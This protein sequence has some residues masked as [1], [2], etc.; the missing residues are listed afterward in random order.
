MSMIIGLTGP[1]GSGK[2]S[3]AEISKKFGLRVIDCD[4][5]ARRAVEP[6]T[7]GLIELEK[8]FG[9]EILNADG[10]LNRSRLAEIAFSAPSKTRLLNKTLLPFIARL[11]K[12]E[13][14]DEPVLLDAPTLFESGVD[15]ICDKTVAI[16]SDEDIRIKRIISR[17][18]LTL[19]Q[20][21][22]RVSAGKDDD[23]YKSRADY[24]LYNNAHPDDFEA[25]V[26]A[27]FNTIFGGKQND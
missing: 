21:K 16:L 11:V 8:V 20:A 10:T 14:G 2:S 3:A 5:L 17:D 4:K 19:T 7:Q 1:T 9:A 13:I 27:L 25:R 15:D 12:D 24:I 18:N 23:F 26:T 22:T 6:G